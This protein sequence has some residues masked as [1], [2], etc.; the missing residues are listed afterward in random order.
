VAQP[1]AQPTLTFISLREARELVTQRYLWPARAVQ[2]VLE[3]LGDPNEPVRWQ[4]EGIENNSGAPTETVLNR[5][6]QPAGLS[7]SWEESWVGRRVE[8]RTAAAQGGVSPGGVVWSSHSARPTQSVS[9]LGNNFVVY[10]IR[11]AREDI[12]RRLR[13]DDEPASATDPAPPPSASIAD[14]APPSSASV[15]EPRMPPKDWFARARE[16]HGRRPRESL[17]DYAKRLHELMQ[18]AP[19]TNVWLLKTLRRR[20]DDRPPRSRPQRGP[21]RR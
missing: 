15:A 13:R 12:E 1:T 14:P 16:Q 10:G 20:L 7:V 6:W 17:M 4:Y 5:L 21:R 8:P 18:N 9:Q 2:L 3:W 19:V 11:V